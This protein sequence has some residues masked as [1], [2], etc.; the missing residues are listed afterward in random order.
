MSLQG[1]TI[2]LTGGSRG[3]GRAI[4]LRCARDGANIIIA[5][6]TSEPHPKLPGT[7]HSVAAEVEAAGGKALPLI[8]DV[9]N[10]VRIDE[11]VDE[12]ANHFGGLD[13]VVNNAGAISLTPTTFTPMKKVDLM[14]GVNVRA[15]YACSRAAIPYLKQAENAHI[16]NMSPPIDMDPRWFKNHVAYTIS[17]YG[18]TM[19]TIGMSAELK[20]VGI[21]VNSL[22]PR[23]IIDT[24]AL[25]LVGGIAM[26]KSG[27]TTEIMADATYAILTS[28]SSEVTGNCFI[29]ED[30][31]RSH[32]VT[33]FEKYAVEPGNDL[34][35]DLYVGAG[36][37]GA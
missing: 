4:A 22:W 28:D 1:K 2:F 24:I 13:A 18:M 16:I 7:I 17:K 23:T 37:Y 12:G 21:A 27:R 30:L 6:K 11:A 29:D 34:F 25:R 19:C 8:V 31:L 14:L 32:G 20:G 5:A 15:A 10:D 3:I 26:A 36:P 9:R 33:D 35:T